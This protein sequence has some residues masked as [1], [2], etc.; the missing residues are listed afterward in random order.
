MI[1]CPKIEKAVIRNHYDVVTPFYRLFWGPHIHHGYWEADEPS[2]LAQEQL[3]VTL[4]TQAGIFDGA[5]VYDI[6]CG[7]GGSSRWLAKHHYC[8]VT[9]VTLSPIQRSWATLVTRLVT[10][11]PRPTYLAADAEQLELPAA[12]ADFVWSIECTEHL[13]DKPAFFR[14]AAGWLKP[15]GRFALGAWLAGN[16][17]LSEE[18]IELART[19]CRGMFCPSLGSQDD[20]VGWFEA[21]GMKMVS[22]EICTDKVKKTWEICLE[23]VERS[24]VKRLAKCLGKNHLLFLDHFTAILQ[25]YNTGA[26][27]YGLFV[28]EKNRE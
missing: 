10:G 18:Q 24:G 8:R 5:V 20:Y 12:S 16:P 28:A 17:P 14:R 27:E 26:M 3:T 21:A 19:V 1:T 25:A 22:R 4:A 9:G 15:G 23:R 6:G 2:R 7:M 13:F 11:T